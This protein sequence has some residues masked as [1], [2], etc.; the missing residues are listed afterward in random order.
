M[1]NVSKVKTRGAPKKSFVV[2]FGLVAGPSHAP[3]SV[4][5]KSSE[6]GKEKAVDGDTDELG[7]WD[8]LVRREVAS[9]QVTVFDV[10]YV[11]LAKCHRSSY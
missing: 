3:H 7:R 2:N 5:E 8:V 1:L 9:K 11:R 4:P 10:R 6:K